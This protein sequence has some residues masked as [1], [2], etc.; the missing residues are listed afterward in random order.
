L[1]ELKN[2]MEAAAGLE[3]AKS[4]MTKEGVHWSKDFV[5]HL[6]TVHFALM[7][8][9]VGLLA[10]ALAHPIGRLGRALKQIQE[11]EKVFEL[12][13]RRPDHTVG[14]N[15]SDWVG[16]WAEAQVNQAITAKRITVRIP[17]EQVIQEHGEVV[18]PEFSCI[19]PDG[20]RQYDLNQEWVLIHS[21]DE[22]KLDHAFL[23][24][25][26]PGEGVVVKTAALGL[27]MDM[28]LEE[29]KRLWD[30]LHQHMDIVVPGSRDSRLFLWNGKHA[31]WDEYKCEDKKAHTRISAFLDIGLLFISLRTFNT[32]DF[33][34][35][36]WFLSKIPTSRSGRFVESFPELDEV[37]AGISNQGL[38]TVEHVLKNR[39][40]ESA[41]SFEAFG[42]KVPS[43]VV[44]RFGILLVIAVQVYFLTHLVELS[45]RLSPTDPGWEVAWVGVYDHVVARLVYF[46]TIAVLPVLSIVVLG[47]RGLT[48]LPSPE[49]WVILVAV[50]VLALCLAFWI[51]RKTPRRTSAVGH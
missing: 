48:Q 20:L 26:L 22:E 51:W 24:T 31:Q 47:K 43:A 37:S 16:E 46:C 18:S 3:T 12:D 29:F 45:K 28:K 15:Y 13:K 1:A 34:G 41:E 39:P 23:Q 44:M 6:R 7:A 19:T 50:T 8:V 14:E 9:S 4:A 2:E 17:L 42:I 35:Q 40:N 30:F 21:S 32:V 11:I 49:S 38:D 5:E 25:E 10:L 27:P 33:D 36:G